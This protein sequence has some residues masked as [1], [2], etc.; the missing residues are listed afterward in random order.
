MNPWKS[1]AQQSITNVCKAFIDKPKRT[2]Y[3]HRKHSK[4][5]WECTSSI[6]SHGRDPIMLWGYFAASQT[7]GT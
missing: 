6:Y 7:G 5:L 1:K 4:A 2:F 3:Q